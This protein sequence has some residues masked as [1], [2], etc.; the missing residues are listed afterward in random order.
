[1]ISRIARAATRQAKRA[2]EALAL[3]REHHVR[4]QSEI[5][6]FGRAL[7]VLARDREQNIR[8]EGEDLLSF[9]IDALLPS[10]VGTTSLH[11]RAVNADEAQ[12]LAEFLQA[13]RA[14][15]SE[16]IAEAGSA[17]DL[18]EALISA[19]DDLHAYVLTHGLV[20][21]GYLRS[22]VAL[23]EHDLEKTR[24]TSRASRDQWPEVEVE[25]PAGV[26]KNNL[27]LAA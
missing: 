27:A 14:L 13:S 22:E 3:A 15:S 2:S 6:D 19:L 23:A 16:T 5:D 1:M 24:P 8:W 25:R 21:D 7:F 20:D 11:L 17:E 10:R 18:G 9:A 12:A 4:A 26:A